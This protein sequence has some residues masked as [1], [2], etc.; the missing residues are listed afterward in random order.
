[1]NYGGAGGAAGRV[2]LSTRPD[3]PLASAPG[4]IVSPTSTQVTGTIGRHHL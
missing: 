3:R 2:Q 4:A 1:V